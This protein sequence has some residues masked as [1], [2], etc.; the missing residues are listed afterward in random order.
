MG[1]TRPYKAFP[2]FL[3]TIKKRFTKK[4]PWNILITAIKQDIL[5]IAWQNNN[6]ILGL[7][8]IYIIDKAKDWIERKRKRPTKTFINGRLVREVFGDTLVK[9]LPIPCFIDDYNQNMG[10]VNLVN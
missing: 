5:Y 2:D 8:N 4:L 3:S 9:E 10:G 7:S 6:I 1:I